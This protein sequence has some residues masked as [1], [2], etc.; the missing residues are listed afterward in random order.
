MK[1]KKKYSSLALLLPMVAL[2]L[3]ACPKSPEERVVEQRS[4][5]KARLLG[6]IVE[7][8][9]V[10]ADL[11]EEAAEEVAEA[12]AEEQASEGPMDAAAADAGEGEAMETAEATV[13]IRQNV[14]IDI[15][16]QHD[17][18]DKLAGITLDIE[19]VDSN[20]V[21]KNVWKLW[22]DTTALAKGTGTQFGHLLEDVDYVE[23]DGFNV[24]VRSPVPSEERGEY[25][26]FSGAAGD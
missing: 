24:E 10:L 18:P 5:Y 25:R 23:G 9:P 17:S 8:D 3:A 20:K 2:I 22:V 11:T 26:E 14:R 21:E 16:L 4:Y 19:M 13:S 6:F 12:V 7:A 1:T 15:L